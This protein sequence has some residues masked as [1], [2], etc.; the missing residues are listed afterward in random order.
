MSPLIFISWWWAKTLWRGALG[1]LSRRYPL[2]NESSHHL[3]VCRIKIH[4]LVHCEFVRM[5]FVPKQFHNIN[6]SKKWLRSRTHDSVW[7]M[8]DT[9]L[10]AISFLVVW[11]KRSGR[12]WPIFSRVKGELGRGERRLKFQL[13]IDR[14]LRRWNY[15]PLRNSG[16]S[17]FTSQKTLLQR[18]P[19]NLW[20]WA[21][22][23]R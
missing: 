13:L 6:D 21:A 3:G 1:G 12:G 9:A 4:E 16:Y 22:L 2:K 14:D 11:L 8:F 7:V 18:D 17:T 23:P 10:I 15:T 19:G 20:P 5:T